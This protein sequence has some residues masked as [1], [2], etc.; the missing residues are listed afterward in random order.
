MF[1]I[2]DVPGSDNIVVYDGNNDDE[3]DNQ[4]GDADSGQE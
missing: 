1:D 3:D 4:D 2:T